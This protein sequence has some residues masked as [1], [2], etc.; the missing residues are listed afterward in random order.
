LIFSIVITAVLVA[1]DQW[2]KYLATIYLTGGG[3]MVVVPHFLGLR[4]V[5]N[6][7]AAF[8]MLSN[9]TNFLIIVTAVALVI[10]AYVFWVKKYGDSFETFC[11]TL[12]IAGGIGNLIDRVLNGFV[13]DYFEFLFMDFAVFNVADVYVCT[14]IALYAVYTVYTEYIKKKKEI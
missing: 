13:V 8:S 5:E 10:M 6:T 3:T 2:S 7:G 1:L 14:G 11:F 9:S 12:I 4:Y